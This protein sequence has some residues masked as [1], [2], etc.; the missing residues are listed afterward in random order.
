MDSKPEDQAIHKQLMLGSEDGIGLGAN[1]PSAINFDGHQKNFEDVVE[2]IKQGR[3]P[4]VDGHE[5]RRTIVLINAIYQ[6]AKDG[7]RVEVNT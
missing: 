1:D 2:A 6:S 7:I 3:P 4:M 5:A